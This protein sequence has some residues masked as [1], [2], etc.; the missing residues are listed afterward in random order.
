[1]IEG[2]VNE[3]YDAVITLTAQGPRGQTRELGAIIDTGYSGNLTLPSTIV[4]ELGL[5]FAGR[6]QAFLAD[7]T[8]VFFD[9]YEATVLWD[10]QP[11][12]I[13]VHESNATPLV[14]MALLRGH[15]LN[16]DVESGGRVA[17]QA[18]S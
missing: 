11:R 13:T 10:G 2:V 18:I 3:S 14:G 7:A 15:N 6:V 4:R 17:I 1:M 12:Q 8:R 16:I 9:V 5:S